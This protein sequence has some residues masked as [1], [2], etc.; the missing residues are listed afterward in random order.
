MEGDAEMTNLQKLKVWIQTYWDYLIWETPNPATQEIMAGELRA[1]G[2]IK[3]KI[4]E[5]EEA[6]EK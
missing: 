4:S 5:L 3:S 6:S 2:R 1:L